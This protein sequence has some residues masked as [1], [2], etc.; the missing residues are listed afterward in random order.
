M[1]EPEIRR[2]ELW[3]LKRFPSLDQVAAGVALEAIQLDQQDWHY[4]KQIAA[5]PHSND[6]RFQSRAVSYR[7]RR[8][9]QRKLR[10][11]PGGR[12]QTS[13]VPR[14]TAG[15]GAWLRVCSAVE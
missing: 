6:H 14:T 3:K 10:Q 8:P 4:L 11:F 15:R 7:A 5:H 1:A 13:D 2:T 9:R 12:L